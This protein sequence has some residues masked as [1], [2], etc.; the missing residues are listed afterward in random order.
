MR[1]AHACLQHTALKAYINTASQS[2][3][4]D[5]GNGVRVGSVT[6]SGLR[7]GELRFQGQTLHRRLRLSLLLL[8]RA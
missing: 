2:T 1:R 4:R 8:R 7:S 3:G 6:H 5:E